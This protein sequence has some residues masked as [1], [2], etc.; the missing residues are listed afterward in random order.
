MARTFYI[1]GAGMGTPDTLTG[2]AR[3]ALDAADAVFAT[4]RLAAL[5]PE[6]EVCPFTELAARA[7]GAGG[8]SIAVLVSGDVG[9]FSVAA[10]LRQQLAPHGEVRLIC[11]LPACNISAQNSACPMMMSACAACT[12]A[13]AAFSAR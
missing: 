12:G 9:F 1:I 8:Q 5:R 11:G 3:R 4:A 10:R 6:A 2:E 7:I 13:R